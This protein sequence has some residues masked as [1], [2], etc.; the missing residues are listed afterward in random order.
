MGN[1]SR[2]EKV[3]IVWQLDNRKLFVSDSSRAS[4]ICATGRKYLY[5]YMTLRTQTSLTSVS[6]VA[7]LIIP[8]SSTGKSC[9]VYQIIS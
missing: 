7:E 1:D 8:P 6:M 3:S 4:V 2:P 9:N 5:P